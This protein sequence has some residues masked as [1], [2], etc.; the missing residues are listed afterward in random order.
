MR[1]L[2]VAVLLLVS[3]LMAETQESAYYRAMKAEEAGDI[4]EAVKA[5][6]E[7]AALPGPYTAEIQDIIREYKIALGQVDSVESPEIESSIED[8]VSPRSF[9]VMGDLGFYGLHYSEYDGIDR[10]GEFGGDVFL[11]VNPFVEYSV[12]DWTHSFGMNVTGDW[13]VANDDMPALDTCDWKLA[14]GLEYSLLGPSI[15]VDLGVDF[16]KSQGGNFLPAFYGWV[17]QDFFR[18][19]K[20]RF[21]LAAWAYYDT[22]GPMSYALYGSWH[23][24]ATQG[25]NG[26]VYIGVRLEAD[27]VLD[28]KRYL[29]DYELAYDAAYEESIYGSYD[30]SQDYNWNNSENGYQFGDTRDPMG[31]CLAERGPECFSMD[32]YV[33]DSLYRSK[34]ENKGNGKEE[35][36]KKDSEAVSVVVPVPKYYGMWI[37][38]TLRSK[39]SYKFKTNITLEGR[40]NL[41][42]GF[43]LDG[44]DSDYEKIRKFN[45]TWG[46]MS[47]WKPG[48]VSIYLGVEQL[49]RRYQLPA[50][51]KNVYAES[52]LLTQLKVGFKW[53]I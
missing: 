23:R 32:P 48:S 22:D 8:E 41:F 35:N 29:A 40:L 46:L 7:A 18:F 9:H 28:Y 37:G 31:Q 12:G 27:S 11:N 36:E 16:V 14:L 49:Y 44:P 24:F 13:F 15:L 20:Q 5:F 33:L 43:I 19:E 21:G 51:Y 25:W 26:A 42:Y 2:A 17:E 53:D 34:N 6:E 45:G 4:P 3:V 10:T 1:S 52:S 38:P 30:N 39:I 47:Y 50:Y